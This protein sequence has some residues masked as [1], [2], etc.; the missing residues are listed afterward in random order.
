MSILKYPVCLIK[1]HDIDLNENIMADIIS[2]KRNW[3][4]PCHR[5][6]L[7]EMHDGAI[8]GMT[9]TITE[10]EAKRVKRETQSEIE[11]FRR[12]LLG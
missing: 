5:C 12:I 11:E 10:A 8:S 9:I 7:Y 6:G 1:G 3:L 4:C 2:D